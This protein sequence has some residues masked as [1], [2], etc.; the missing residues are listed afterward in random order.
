LRPP[1]A[2]QDLH[3][4]QLETDQQPVQQAGG[5]AFQMVLPIEE[6]ADEGLRQLMLPGC[7]GCRFEFR[8]ERRSQLGDGTQAAECVQP[9]R[10]NQP[11]APGVGAGREVIPIVGDGL[12]HELF[13]AAAFPPTT[14]RTTAATA[15]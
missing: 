9:W 8:M 12:S 2:Q 5:G 10:V 7:G 14:H 6:F 15:C 3:I 1:S 4:F 11:A 13:P